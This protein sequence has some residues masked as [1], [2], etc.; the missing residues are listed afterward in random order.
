MWAFALCWSALAVVRDKERQSS[1]EP[2]FDFS[3]DK[4]CSCRLGQLN[5]LCQCCRNFRSCQNA[6]ECHWQ[7]FFPLSFIRNACQDVHAPRVYDVELQDLNT[8]GCDCKRKNLGKQCGCCHTKASC[9][10]MKACHWDKGAYFSFS[11]TGKSCGT[12]EVV[13]TPPEL[14]EEDDD[15]V[16]SPHSYRHGRHQKGSASKSGW[17]GLFIAVLLC[18]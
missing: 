5:S 16:V 6:A 8:R 10:E 4:G 1:I 12:R 11:L 2:R 13:P 15:E 14:L 18:L 3:E 7:S 17:L 9:S